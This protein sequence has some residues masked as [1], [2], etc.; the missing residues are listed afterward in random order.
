MPGIDVETTFDLNKAAFAGLEEKFVAILEE[1]GA[2]VL[3]SSQSKC[4]VARSGEGETLLDSGYSEMIESGPGHNIWSLEV[5]YTRP[6]AQFQE[7]GVAGI[8]SGYSERGYSYKSKPRGKRRKGKKKGAWR[9]NLSPFLTSLVA[10]II[11]TGIFSIKKR[12]IQIKPGR[13]L[14]GYVQPAQTKTHKTHIEMAQD[15]AVVIRASIFKKGLKP[16]LFLT[17]GFNEGKRKM[18]E[19]AQS[20]FRR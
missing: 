2:E 19:I 10:W 3:E 18:S 12:D 17:H 14:K 15:L 9:D 5:G 13:K 1:T 16:V 6:Y 20:I 4:P 8:E 7:F 11:A